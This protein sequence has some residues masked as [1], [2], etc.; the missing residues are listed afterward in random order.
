[1]ADDQLTAIAHGQIAQLAA[2]E[3]LTTAALDHLT[4]ARE[5]TR[6]TPDI[7]SWLATIE[8]TIQADRGDHAAADQAID[9][10]QTVLDQPGGRPAPA[11]FDDHGT[12]HR[13]AVIGH[14]RLRAGDHCSARDVLTA[15]VSDPR[16]TWRRQRVLVLIDLATAELQSGD[17][18]AAW[19][20]ATQAAELLQHAVFAVG[21]ARLRAFRTAANRPLNGGSLRVVDEYL[22]RIAA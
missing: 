14:V 10:A 9:R 18:P 17:L 5:H 13:T 12:V 6:S 4:T 21:I 16:P 7:A 19:S 20:H 22:T 1:V 2:A 8:A 3:G 15:A 11:S